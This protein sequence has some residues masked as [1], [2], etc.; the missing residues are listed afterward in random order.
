MYDSSHFFSK[1]VVFGH[2]VSG[3]NVVDT[4]ENL[5]IDPITNRPLKNV[6]IS[7]CGQIELI[8]SKRMNFLKFE[9]ISICF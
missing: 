6:I 1:H 3:Q 5:P 9:A 8:T 4:I 7:H 2:V